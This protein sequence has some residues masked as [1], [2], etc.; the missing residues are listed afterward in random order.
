VANVPETWYTKTFD[1][2]HIAYQVAG[3]GPIDLLFNVGLISHVEAAWE[4][5]GHAQFFRRLASFSRLIRFDKRGSGLSDP[6]SGAATL[7]ERM[8]DVRA[9]LD[10]VGSEHAV[11]TGVSEGG[12]IAMLFAAVYPERTSALVLYGTGARVCRAPDY[13]CGIERALAEQVVASAVEGWGRPGGPLL[14]L[15][16]PGAASDLRL[17]EWWAHYERLAASPGQFADVTSLNLDIDVRSVL[18]TIQAPTLV[19]HR[20]DDLLFPVCHGR[21]LA[22]HIPGAKLRVLPGSDHVFWFGDVDG[23]ADEIEEFLVG[24]RHTR[25]PDRVLSTIVFTDIVGSTQR[26]AALGDRRWGD[27][28]DR[29]DEFV[30]R[31]LAHFGGR[32][33]KT[34]GDG[35]VASFDGPARAVRCARTITAEVRSLDLEVR[36]GVHTGECEVRGNDLAGIAVHVAARVGALAPP[37]EVLVS[38]TVRDLVA[39]SGIRFV[40]RGTHVLKGVPEEWRLFAVE[41]V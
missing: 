14:Q 22:E 21:Y 37:G 13:G 12:A 29:H 26:A 18:P 23:I 39:G 30:R 17:Q 24:A 9:V 4:L 36:A 19:V 15:I 33:I 27:L 1:G 41:S 8:D 28:L 38:S 20:D 32:E 6:V 16:A 31:Q 25:E 10:A 2:L 34:V 35:F 11:L 7:E 40:E 5:A 3:E